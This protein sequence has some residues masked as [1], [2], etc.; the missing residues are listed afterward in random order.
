MSQTVK[1]KVQYIDGTSQTF[2]WESYPEEDEMVSMASNL[3]KSFREEYILL[4]MGD[5]FMV[6][7][8]QNIKTIEV[9]T[10][11]AKLPPTAIHGVRLVE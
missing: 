4:E 6:L 1:M 10:V 5:K 7:L 11:P 8:K 3:Q 9:N 2:E